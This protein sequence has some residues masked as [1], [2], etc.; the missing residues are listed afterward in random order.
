MQVA[1][2]IGLAVPGRPIPSLVAEDRSAEGDCDRTGPN[3]LM[4]T[5]LLTGR[6]ATPGD[7]RVQDGTT[8]WRPPSVKAW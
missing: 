6:A 2:L 8:L 3:P 5:E 7:E 1:A 4:L